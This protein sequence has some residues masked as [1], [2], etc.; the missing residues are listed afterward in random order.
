MFPEESVWAF[1]VD[2]SPLIFNTFPTEVKFVFSGSSV[3]AE[4][5]APYA[6]TPGTEFTLLV[7]P[8]VI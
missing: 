6:T 2:Y 3:A 1:E 8:R 7:A 5:E 4:N